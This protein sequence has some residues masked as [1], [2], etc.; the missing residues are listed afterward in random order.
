MAIEPRPTTLARSRAAGAKLSPVQDPAIAAAANMMIKALGGAGNIVD[1]HETAMTR[2]RIVV[3]DPKQVDL[4]AL[5]A[6]GASGIMEMGNVYHILLGMQARAYNEEM[7][8]RLAQE[9]AG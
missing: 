5:R 9:R 4:E 3:D 2:I 7:Q 6:A 1:A 8:V